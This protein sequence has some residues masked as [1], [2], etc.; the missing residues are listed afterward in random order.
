MPEILFCIILKLR[1]FQFKK[2]NKKK[3]PN[4]YSQKNILQS[5]NLIYLKLSL[6]N[7]YFYCIFHG[8]L[9]QQPYID[10]NQPDLDYNPGAIIYFP[11][12]H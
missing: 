9:T 4:I 3:N 10:Y 6:R 7:E 2:Q 11:C 5:I 1:L 8:F 12:E